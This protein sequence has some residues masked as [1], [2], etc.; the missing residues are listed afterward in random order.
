MLILGQKS[1]ILGPTIFKIP[2]P[3]W[4]Y[5]LYHSSNIVKA[6]PHNAVWPEYP[7]VQSNGPWHKVQIQKK[8]MVTQILISN[9]T[10]TA[11]WLSIA[12]AGIDVNSQK[13]AKTFNYAFGKT[14][15]YITFIHWK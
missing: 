11:Y 14:I 15:T 13:S 2:Q 5:Y 7:S 10:T 12:W 8:K 9:L 1:C 4:Y 3:N 6:R